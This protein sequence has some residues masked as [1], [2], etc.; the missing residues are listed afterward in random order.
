MDTIT[1]EPPAEPITGT[2]AVRQ[3]EPQQPATQDD[4]RPVD[5]ILLWLLV[6]RYLAWYVSF[7]SVAAL[8]LVTA[9]IFHA[10]ARARGSTG[11][12]QLIWRASPRLLLLSRS[13]GA[14]KSTLLDLIVILTGSRRGKVPR[15]TPARLAQ[16]T[17]QAHETVCIDE[18]RLVFGAGARHQ[19]LQACL[20]AGYTPHASYEVS[21][22]SLSLFGSVAIATKESLITEAT[23]AVDGDESSLG[24]LIDRCFT[25]I[26]AAPD[27]PMPEVGQRAEAEGASLARALVKW[28]SDNRAALEQAAQDIA[29]QDFE[30]ATERAARGEKP[31]KSLRLFQIGRP[32]LACARVVGYLP[33]AEDGT[34]RKNVLEADLRAALSGTTGSGGTGI[35][36][37]LETLSRK[38]EGRTVAE[39]EGEGEFYDD[40]PGGR[41]VYRDD[42]GEPDSA[43]AAQYTA[44]YAVT[45]PGV[46][47]VSFTF[48]GE[49]PALEAAQ[50]VCQAS[51]VEPLTWE[52][53]P[54]VPGM[55][56]ATVHPAGPGGPEVS[57][58]VREITGE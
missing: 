37:E 8:N 53:S 13:R 24:D 3:P 38:W 21:K 54:R 27:R 25:V 29:D 20:L 36:A 4:D 11:I 39:A 46:Q 35:M 30:E 49:W 57:Y 14:G 44:G 22:T 2:L 40:E 9:W 55:W 10:C 12:G 48:P 31:A 19:D 45:G 43:P 50:E 7:Q 47:A 42:G 28:T 33:P 18:G 5:G 23:K 52:P 51:A 15:I 17:G 1:T 58:A 6:R 26:L 34:E 16:I 41:I 56:G 32:L